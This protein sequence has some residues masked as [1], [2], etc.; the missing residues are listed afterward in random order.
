MAKRYIRY[1][2]DGVWKYASVKDIGVLEELL[3]NDKT[4][5]VSAINELISNGGAQQAEIDDIK[6]IQTNLSSE[7]EQAKAELLKKADVE[8]VDGELV[9]KVDLSKYD[10]EYQATQNKLLEKVDYSQYQQ[11]YNVLVEN[12]NAKADL[13]TVESLSQ[14]IANQQTE[15]NTAKSNIAGLETDVSNLD[16]RVTAD[17]QSLNTKASDLETRVGTTEADIITIDQEVDNVK[18]ELSTT[19]TNL[20]AVEGRVAQAETSITQN[21]NEIASK[22]SQTQYDTDIND[23]TTGLKT[24]ISN[25]E[26]SIT[27][28]AESIALKAEKSEVY[29]KTETDTK[30]GQKVDTT[31]YNNKVSEIE[32]DVDGITQRVSNV[33]GTIGTGATGETGTIKSELSRIDQKAD[34]IQLE[35]NTLEQTVGSQGTTISEHESRISLAEGN[36]NLK[37]N[38]TDVYKKNEVDNKL[39]TKVDSTVYNNKMA[40]IDVDID[41]ISQTVSSQ[42]TSIN[43]INGTVESHTTQIST[44]DQKADSISTRVTETESDISGLEG[45]M[46]TAETQ[47][48]QNK[49]SI[50]LKADNSVVEDLGTRLTDAEAEIQ[51][52]SDAIT[53]RVTLTEWDGA[54]GVNKWIVSKYDI[55]LGSSS[56]IPTFAHLNGLNPSQVLEF[57]DSQRM[58]PFTGDKYIAHFFTNVFLN[59]AKTIQLNLTHDDSIAVYMNGAMISQLQGSTAGTASLS[60]RKGWNTVEILHYEHT[61]TEYVDLGLKLSSQVDKLT[62][63][64]GIGDKNDTRLRQA[65]TSIKQTAEAIE[66]KAD[67]TEV[68]SLGNRISNNE[69]SISLLNDEIA[70]KAS[71]TELDN[72]SQRLSNAESSITVNSNAIATKVEQTDFD[73]LNGRVSDAETSITQ[74]NNQIVLKVSQNDFDA[75]E[76]RVSSAETSITQTQ[77]SIAL[78]A[79]KTALDTVTGRLEDAEAELT[80]QADE[81]ATKVGKTE[82]DSYASG[83]KKIRYIRDYLNGSSANTSNHWIEIQAIVDGQNV[84]QGKAV[85]ASN[86]QSSLGVITD[87][88][89]TSYVNVGSG[90]TWVQVDLGQVHENVEYLHIWHYYADGR[91]YNDTKTQVSEDGVIW[92]TLF[93]SS[94]TGKYKETSDGNVIPVNSG[95]SLA[96]LEK[97]MS[98]AETSITQTSEQIELKAD[99]STTYTKTEVDGEIDRIDLAINDANTRITQNASSISLKANSTDVYTKSQTDTKLGSKANQSALDTTNSNLNALVTRVT[100]AESELTVQAGQI[101][102]KVEQSEFDVLENRMS[103]AESTI[104][105]HSN[106]I[107]LK[108]TQSEVD[109]ALADAKKYTDSNTGN[110]VNNTTK[111]GNLDG[112]TGGATVENQD[113]FGTTVPVQ[114]VTT[115]GNVQIYSEFFNVDPSK[116]YEVTLWFKSDGN[117]G[118]DYIGLHAYNE[119]SNIGVNMISDSTGGDSTSANTNPYFWSG[120]GSN[121]NGEWVRR[122]AYIM[123]T[124]TK[125]SDMKGIGYN[126]SSNARMLPNTNKIRIRWLNYYNDGVT[127]TL[128]IANPKVVE[129]DPNAVIYGAKANDRASS[130]ETRMSSAESSISV[131]AGQIASKVG[132]TEVTSAINDIEIGGVNLLPNSSAEIVNEDGTPVDWSTFNSGVT[133]LR[134]DTGRISGNCAVVTVSA[135]GGGFRTPSTPEGSIIGDKKYTISFWMKADADCTIGHLMKFNNASGVESNP[136]TSTSITVKAN[137]WVKFEE[138]FTAPSDAVRMSTTP[139]LMSG[140]ATT[141]INLYVDEVQIEEGTKASSWS[142]SQADVDSKLTDLN[143]RLSYAEQVIDPNQIVATVTSSETFSNMMDEKANA[144]TLADYPTKDEVGSQFTDYDATVDEKIDGKIGNIDLDKFEKFSTLKQTTDNITANFSSAGG[145]NLIKNSVGFAGFEFWNPTNG[146][147]IS[148]ISNGDLDKIGF[149]SGFVAYNHTATKTLE[150]YVDVQIGKD[151]TVSCTILKEVTNGT[152]NDWILLQAYE[153]GVKVA[154]CGT[155][156]GKTTNGFEQFEATF[157]ATSAQV[158]I[159]VTFGSLAEGIMTGVMMNVGNSKLQWSMARG[160]MY[161]SAVKMDIKGIRVSQIE[162]EKETAFTVMTPQRFAGYYDVNGDGII[163]DSDDSI[164]EVFKMSEDKFVMK[165]AVVKEEIVMGSFKIQELQTTTNRGWAFLPNSTE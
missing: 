161:N 71:Q 147:K 63:H 56:A 155:G 5:I 138:T 52:N 10:T 62:A 23:A 51:I 1:L 80:V 136:I 124:G 82:F 135:N 87:G 154:E 32:V 42:Q 45:R 86:G 46:G 11:E 41:G 66:L 128:W 73:L 17:I 101:Q 77:N 140:Y 98:S 153:N 125:A 49:N 162:G 90:L 120:G 58:Q 104:T 20:T 103:T 81:I 143:V 119:G 112:W 116:A 94:V 141:P 132:M 83:V 2:E 96:N 142:P 64:I 160:E 79:D 110:L 8:Y 93:D 19:V 134:I 165:R 111:S 133:D 85:T 38:A 53:Q 44:I 28:Q 145:V 137:E 163:D 34:G 16:I 25:A 74:L 54:L 61:N 92:R 157:K 65:E 99:K 117:G 22:V 102:A 68:T 29:T 33:E 59:N 118:S 26:T 115:S 21:A 47:I 84:A 31:T 7:L 14:S 67:K 105:Q 121:H 127:K 159:L 100:N 113:F 97:R 109:Q 149:G 40:E 76:N 60:L 15:I 150:Q 158:R 12:I 139:R 89:K 146:S 3:T 37:A 88:N 35:V 9:K 70:L 78:K 144:E 156:S 123:P 48:T 106:Q 13:I 114:K 126:V 24:R 6:V 130:L 107:A 152:S 75:L 95:N 4:N 55:D 129:V 148:P 69:A 164:D 18:G 57:N 91:T 151:Y 36:I 50:A 122:T 30:L 131:Q 39:G 43:N 27:Q 72:Y 108:V